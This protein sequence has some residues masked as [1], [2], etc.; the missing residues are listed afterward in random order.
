M[1]YKSLK[2]LKGAVEEAIKKQEEYINAFA[3]NDNPQVKELFTAAQ[4]KKD[5]LKAV[6]YYINTG[7]KAMLRT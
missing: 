5:A 4:A 2:E 3:G 1:A 6:L 7:S